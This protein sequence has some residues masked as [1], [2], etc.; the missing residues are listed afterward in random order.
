MKKN[1]VRIGTTAFDNL[2]KSLDVPDSEYERRITTAQLLEKSGKF[3]GVK[4]YRLEYAVVYPAGDDTA[5]GREYS[6]DAL[7]R[8]AGN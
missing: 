4:G 8:M 1:E 3:Q 7:H 6:W 5:Q 2:N